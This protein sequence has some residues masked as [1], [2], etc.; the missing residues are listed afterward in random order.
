LSSS[1]TQSKQNSLSKI[2]SSGDTAKEEGWLDA[3]IRPVPQDDD[4]DDDD[5]ED[6]DNGNG[7]GDDD[8]GNGG[9]NG[10]GGEDGDSDPEDVSRRKFRRV[11]FG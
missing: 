5:D 8:D 11:G 4:G 6:G 7:G 2:R 1:A 10:D 3:P 9:G